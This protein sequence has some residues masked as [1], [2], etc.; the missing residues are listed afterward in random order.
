MT[1][2]SLPY[3]GNTLHVYTRVSTVAQ[4]DKGTS[5]QSQ[6]EL[7]KKKA[8]ELGFKVKHWD[9]GGKSSHHEDIAGRPVLFEL[10]ESVKSGFVKHLWVYD[11]SRLSRNDQVASVFR[12][13]CNR[14]GVTL[15][16]KDGQFDLSSP[17]DMLLKQLLDAVA[18]FDNATRAERSRLGKLQRVRSGFWHGGPPPFGYKLNNRKLETNPAEAQWVKRIFK[19]LLKGR[20]TPQI[21]TLLDSNAVQARRGGLWSIGSIQAMLKNSHYAGHY[22]YEDK[23]SG[24]KVKVECPSIVDVLTWNAVQNIRKRDVSRQSQKNATKKFYLLRDLMF[25]GHC[26][27]PLSARSNPKKG[28][29]LY[30]CPNKERVWA[31]KGKSDTPWVRGT[32]CGFERS[33]NITR[34]DQTVWQV[35]K[36]IHSESSILREE[37]K[38]RVLKEHGLLVKTADEIKKTESK[39]RRLQRALSRHNEAVGALEANRVMSRLKDASYKVMMK[40]LDDERLEIE[41][42]LQ[43]AQLDLRGDTEKRKWIDWMKAFSDG[44]KNYDDLTDQQRKSYVDGLVSRIDVFYR[45]KQ[46]EHEL[47]MHF[48]LPVVGDSI[49]YNDSRNKSK[50][51]AVV[52]GRTQGVC[53]VKKKDGRG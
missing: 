46:R 39:I 51:Y 49:K 2:N 45:P 30:Y 3:S 12:Y 23:K 41:S 19:E 16:T 10:Y 26:G 13:E 29:E 40:R 47:K 18:E 6:L 4:A 43:A 52:E 1:S 38:N 11:Q 31:V 50:G 36:D 21:K 25:C 14:Q 20:S 37:V 27:R 5:L 33:M 53:I 35:L 32:G 7:G 28:E 22:V 44:H 9:E 8:R 42:A 48:R 24:Q 34:T 17:T 15:Y